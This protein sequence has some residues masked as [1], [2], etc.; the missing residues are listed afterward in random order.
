[1]AIVTARKRL[2]KPTWEYRVELAP[3]NGKR[4]Q[5]TKAGFKTKKE[6]LKA[7]REFLEKYE[8]GELLQSISESSVIDVFSLWLKQYCI[9]NLAE[10][11]IDNYKKRFRLYISPYIGEYRIKNVTKLMLQDLINELASEGYSLNTVSDICGLLSGFFDWAETNNIISRSP[12]YKLKT[13]KNAKS[14]ENIDPESETQYEH[15]YITSDMWK[16]AE[17]RFP[18]N[19]TAYIPLHI[20]YH[21]G[22]RIGEAYGLVWDD[23]DFENKTLSVNRQIQWHADSTRTKK[24]KKEKNGTSNA[25]NGYWY[26]KPPKYNS[27]RIID[28]DDEILGILKKEY[29]KQ[30]LAAAYY[31]DQ[32]YHYYS[33]KTIFSDIV[34]S[35]KANIKSNI[36]TTKETAYEINFIMRQ[37]SGYYVTPRTMQNISRVMK[38]KYGID[39][40]NFHSLRHTHSTQLEEAGAPYQYIQNRFGHK[41]R[42]TTEVYTDHLTPTYSHRGVKAL[43][44]LY[45]AK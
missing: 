18:E 5:K 19:T 40:F 27:Y 21:T 12:A 8:K 15:I 33:E 41:N 2:G 3:I 44:Q 42:K 11:T 43:K 6:A 36:I 26:F 17:K 29:E 34:N 39:K 38:H 10:T 16:I 20:G 35:R 25:G 23:I 37:Q 7:G 1:M 32:F 31:N 28:L 24:Q 4:N 30:Q 45:N 9:T 22:L 14:N 13:P